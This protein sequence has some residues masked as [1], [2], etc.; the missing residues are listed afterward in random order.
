MICISLRK[1]FRS[2]RRHRGDVGHRAVAAI[3]DLAFGRV[4]GAQDEAAGRRLATAGF[5][6]E[7]KRFAFEDMQVDAIDGADVADDFAEETGFDR[8]VLLQILRPAG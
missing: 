2:L 7:S 8:E 5:T 1:D 3:E 6:D 4:D